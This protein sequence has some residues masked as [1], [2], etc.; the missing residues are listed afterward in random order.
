[1]CVGW[2]VVYSARSLPRP[3]DDPLLVSAPKAK[4]PCFLVSSQIPG[5]DKAILCSAA[6][7]PK[8]RKKG[9]CYSYV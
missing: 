1:M 3:T 9:V 8:T 4:H 2:V 6:G 7:D 5:G